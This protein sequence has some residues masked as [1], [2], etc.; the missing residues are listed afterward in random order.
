VTSHPE[1]GAT[2]PPDTPPEIDVEIVRYA[3][4][5]KVIDQ[6]QSVLAEDSPGEFVSLTAESV[7][8]LKQRYGAAFDTWVDS[9]R[10]DS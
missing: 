2:S 9:I 3:F 1:G 5:E 4:L 10:G 7:D 8:Y 6:A